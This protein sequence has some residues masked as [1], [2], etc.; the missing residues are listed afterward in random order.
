MRSTYRDALAPALADLPAGVTDGASSSIAFV[1]SDAVRA[2][3]PASQP[4]IDAATS[5]FTDGVSA[6][7]LAGAGVVLAGAV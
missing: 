1:Q 2:L 5:A 7:T 4:L 3:G 6:A